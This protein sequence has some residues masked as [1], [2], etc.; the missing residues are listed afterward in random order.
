MEI[1]GRRWLLATVESV[2]RLQYNSP[3][4]NVSRMTGRQTVGRDDGDMAR[5]GSAMT[6]T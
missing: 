5:R 4:L 3:R 6:F 1:L 2:E